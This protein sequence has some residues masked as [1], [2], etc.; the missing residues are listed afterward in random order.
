[1]NLKN[2]IKFKIRK[3]IVYYIIKAGSN[4]EKSTQN[5]GRFHSEDLNNNNNN[6]C[7]MALCLGL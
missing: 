5:N 7:F 2:I 6:N 1:V 4:A 3:K